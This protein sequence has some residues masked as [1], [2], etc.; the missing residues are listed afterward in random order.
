MAEKFIR[1]YTLSLFLILFSLSMLTIV[2]FIKNPVI[3]KNIYLEFLNTKIFVIL[4]IVG[5]IF[6]SVVGIGI[7]SLIR[8]LE[9]K[10]FRNP[11]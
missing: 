5:G 6:V 8:F 11:R 7:Y 3:A 9:K 4:S 10:L 2:V 1:A